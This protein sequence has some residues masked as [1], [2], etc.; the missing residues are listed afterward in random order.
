[1]GISRVFKGGLNWLI[2]PQF[3]SSSLRNA[4]EDDMSVLCGGLMWAVNVWLSS[5][6]FFSHSVF[7]IFV[8]CFP[9]LFLDVLTRHS[10]LYVRFW[11][12]ANMFIW[13]FIWVH[14]TL[15]VH[16]VCVSPWR[17]M[18]TERSLQENRLSVCR[19]FS[20]FQ[21]LWIS[22]RTLENLPSS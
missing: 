7:I 10:P 9:T 14:G 3:S 22:D 18:K 6:M 17:T 15:R 1:M 21:L 2:L 4:T 12:S 19:V 16:C 8:F 20:P 11:P 5:P 13:G